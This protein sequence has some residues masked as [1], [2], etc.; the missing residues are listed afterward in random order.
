MSKKEEDVIKA[1]HMTQEEFDNCRNPPPVVFIGPAPI[2]EFRVHYDG[3]VI[4]RKELKQ[5]PVFNG[6]TILEGI[7]AHREMKKMKNKLY[8]KKKNNSN[9]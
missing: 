2:V 7:A 9:K 3:D 4:Y 1:V 5:D 6:E 8:L